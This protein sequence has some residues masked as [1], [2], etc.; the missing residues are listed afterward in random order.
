MYPYH[1][2]R[3]QALRPA[4]YPRRVA[5]YTWFL[6]KVQNADFPRY[7]LT[8]NEAG[9]NYHNTHFWADEN[10]HAIQP[11]HFQW[12]FAINL[13][14]SIVDDRLIGPFELLDRL[15]GANYYLQFLRH[16]LLQ[17]LEEVPLNRHGKM[18]FLHDGGPAHFSR[19]VCRF[20]DGDYPRRGIGRGE[21]RDI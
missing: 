12:Q 1:V 3:V 20:L 19:M 17:L 18:W 5:F 8:T 9:F 21:P 14:A 6:R 2:H 4:D 7:I 16:D 11:R 15:T 13:W 10:P